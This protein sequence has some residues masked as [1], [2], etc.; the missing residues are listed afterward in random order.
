MTDKSAALAIAEE[1]AAAEPVQLD[2]LAEPETELGRLKVAHLKRGPGRPKGSGNKLVERRAQQLIAM[3]GDPRERQLAVIR[4]NTADLAAWLDCS[5]LEAAQEQRLAFV[6]VAPYVH[7][8]LTPEVNVDNRRVYQL[9]I[10]EG[11]PNQAAAGDGVGLVQV[12]ENKEEEN[13]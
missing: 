5:M 11:E 8:R 13:P 12:I 1:L 2:L 10:I 7:H 3:Y 9:T 6:A 4:M